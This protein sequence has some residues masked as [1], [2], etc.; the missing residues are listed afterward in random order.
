MIP[1]L[2]GP[3]RDQPPPL[4][5]VADEDPQVVDGIV[6]SLQGVHF[7]VATALDGDIP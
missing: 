4:V 2:P 1:R 7:R 6:R 5:L 3:P